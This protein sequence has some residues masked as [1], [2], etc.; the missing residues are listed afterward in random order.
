MPV[1]PAITTSADIIFAFAMHKILN[2]NVRYI[3]LRDRMSVE[4]TRLS[5]KGQIV[6][7]SEIRKR[8]K[9]RRA[10]ASLYLRWEVR[11]Y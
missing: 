5:D 3:L 6:I 1:T 8:M 11:S 10:R 7:P 4:L 9:L 2:N